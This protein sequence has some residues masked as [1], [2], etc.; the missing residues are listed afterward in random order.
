MIT[1]FENRCV[2]K[3]YVILL[4]PIF[5]T[6][7]KGEIQVKIYMRALHH[8]LVLFQQSRN[9]F[10]YES[11]N[12]IEEEILGWNPSSSTFCYGDFISDAEIYIGP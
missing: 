4:R 11:E 5:D 2:L 6:T 3:K 10:R 7:Y 9:F 8:K 1:T 12:W